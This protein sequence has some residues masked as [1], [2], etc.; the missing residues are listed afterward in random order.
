MARIRSIHLQLNTLG[1]NDGG[2]DGDVYLGVCGREFYIDST[3]ND[4][5][6]GASKAYIFGEG[7]NIL[8]ADDNDPRT[9][10]LDTED[11]DRFPMYIRFQPKNR[12]DRWNLQRAQV[13]FNGNF[14]PRWD[15]FGYISHR[16]GIWMGTRASMSV[17]IPPHNDG[18]ARMETDSADTYADA[19][20]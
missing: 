1:V 12:D 10:G 20:G 9:Q 17:A 4:F 18:L 7:A 13:S 5:Q 3:T 16:T 15:T 11:V 14:F 6:S 8:H 2:T 19:R